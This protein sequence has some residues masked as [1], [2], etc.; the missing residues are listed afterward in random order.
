MDLRPKQVD[1]SRAETVLEH[2]NIAVNKNTV[3]GDKSALRPSGLRIGAPALT[4]RNMKE[5]DFKIVVDFLDKGT[6]NWHFINI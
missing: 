4:S 3:P 6:W 2:I 5:E 1:A